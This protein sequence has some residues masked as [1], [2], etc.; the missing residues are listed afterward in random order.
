M[1]KHQVFLEDGQIHVGNHMK[2]KINIIV[3]CT[4]RKHLPPTPGLRLRDICTEDMDEG[5]AAWVQRLSTSKSK[6]I[7]ARELY[8]GDHWTVVKTL[9]KVASLSGLE[10]FIWIC[11]AGYGLI[12]LNTKIKPYSATFSPNDADS[13]YKWSTP[14][15]N[16]SPNRLWWQFH[17]E[18]PGPDVLQPRSIKDIAAK[19]PDSPMLVVASQPYLKAILE[20]V[21]MASR[22]LHD[23][24]LLCVISAG[25]NS[26]P[27]IES[28]LLPCNATLQAEVGGS[29]NSLNARLAR[30]IL[31]ELGENIFKFS[32][33]K[34]QFNTRIATPP[35]D[36]SKRKIIK[37]SEVQ[38]FVL[39]AL[40]ED[41]RASW[42]RLLSKLRESGLACSQERFTSVFK[43][44]EPRNHT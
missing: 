26:L 9:E 32:N 20:D 3:T 1:L 42:T 40:K 4:K 12:A 7:V 16:K 15:S 17:T 43:Q 25:T 6:S 33:L 19:Y 8:A 29:L 23:I 28:N 41:P 10:A 35:R 21:R 5:F 13:V 22:T 24:E 39:A 2:R 38:S 14:D 18:W 11:S 36:K 44:V 31:S 34:A 37:D 30:T 27:G